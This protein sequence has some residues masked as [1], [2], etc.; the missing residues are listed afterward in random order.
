MPTPYDCHHS[1][2][3][4]SHPQAEAVQPAPVIG[5]YANTSGYAIHSASPIVIPYHLALPAKGNPKDFFPQEPICDVLRDTNLQE[6]PWDNT[7]GDN[8]KL[9]EMGRRF[10]LF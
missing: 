1:E 3:Q 2:I 6:I 7:D 9:M 4:L 8:K 10:H 5:S